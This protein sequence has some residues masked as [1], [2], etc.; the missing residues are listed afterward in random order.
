MYWRHIFIPLFLVVGLA[1]AAESPD[2]DEQPWDAAS[3]E[4]LPQDYREAARQY[5]KVPKLHAHWLQQADDARLFSFALEE[6]AKRDGGTEFLTAILRTDSSER[7]RVLVVDT[8]SGYAGRTSE[9][10]ALFEELAVADPSAAVSVAA[11][12]ALVE[13]ERRRMRPLVKRRLA[14]AK[15]QNDGAGADLLW[16]R[17]ADYG[18]GDIR[19]PDFAYR[20]PAMFQ[21]APAKTRAIRVLAFGDFGSGDAEQRDTA[22]AMRALHKKTPFTLGITLGDNFYPLGM[23]DPDLER[24]VTD[25]EDLYSSMGIRFYAALGNHDYG[26][27][28]SPAAQIA[29]SSKSQSW[30]LPAPFYT[31]TAGPAQFFAIDTVRLDLKQLKWLEQAL[32]QS[33]ARWKIVYGHYPIYSATRGDNDIEQQDLIG[34]LL[35]VLKSGKADI[36]LGGHDHN[37]QELKPE[38]G[39]HFF[40]AGAGGATLYETNEYPRTLFKSSVHGFGVLEATDRAASLS[41]V[42]LDGKTLYRREIEK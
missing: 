18:F 25:W 15:Q 22:R 38:E 32:A 5:A 2:P 21:A 17:K 1:G 31:F 26:M 28:D 19:L 41:F 13:N 37:M 12:D 42:G 6:I 30:R 7:R 9:G 20:A 29:Y 3:I 8:L 34:R 39:V 4:R 23:S 24:W 33:K 35:P 14:L 10:K 11:M 40:V 36:Y 27:P 16:R